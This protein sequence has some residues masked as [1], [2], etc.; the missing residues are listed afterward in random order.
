MKI[1]GKEIVITRAK[2]RKYLM[3][4]AVVAVAG[5]GVYALFSGA[6]PADNPVLDVIETIDSAAVNL[7]DTL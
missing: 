6:D 1:A 3:I 7:P 4:A 2:V 5:W